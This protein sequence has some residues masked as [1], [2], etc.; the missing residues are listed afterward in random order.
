MTNER[1]SDAAE[2]TISGAEVSAESLEDCR[3]EL[4]DVKDRLLR[5]LAEHENFRRR[6]E[7]EREDAVK[8]AAAQLVKDLLPAADSL[9]RALEN[10]SPGDDA[11]QSLL[12]RV[13]LTERAL[14]DAFIK[15]GIQKIQPAPGEPFD[16]H[17]HQALFEVEDDDCPPGTV[18]EILQ[19]GYA[20]YER[21]LRPAL[22]G[23]AKRRTAQTQERHG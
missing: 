5:A 1:K 9:S 20:Y 15:H 4:A 6:S 21:L 8:F 10:M 11:L 16:A 19:P 17:R 18:A 2:E 23:V 13:A 14:R 3:A 22:V 7:R 12:A